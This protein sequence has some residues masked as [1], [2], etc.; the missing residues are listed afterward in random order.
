MLY[1]CGRKF[2]KNIAVKN[3][4]RRNFLRT[5]PVAAAASLTLADTSLFTSLAAAQSVP[6]VMAVPFQ[7]LTAQ[8]LQDHFKALQPKSGNET[9]INA[10]NFVVIL[11]VETA[12]TAK[13]FEYHE[14]R[15]H[16]FHILEGSTT[17]ELGGTPKNAR[18]TRPGEWLA[19]ESEGATSITLKKGDMLVVQRGTPHRRIT[20]ESVTL[21]LVSPM[22]TVM[23]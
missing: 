14:G 3:P 16:V 11:T 15:D 23:A 12:K 21:I 2:M 9:V 13:E 1:Y 20:T 10:T 8:T 5:A 4:G 7:L 6:P 19:P 22:G 17:Y 18:K